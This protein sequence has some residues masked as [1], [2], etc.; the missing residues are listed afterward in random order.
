M[1]PSKLFYGWIIILTCF[2]SLIVVFGTRLSFQV[3]FVALTESF[4][5]RRAETAGIFS[6]NMLVFAATAPL[7]GRYLDR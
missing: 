6:V 1:K 3:F 7:F 4:G 2:T 5:W